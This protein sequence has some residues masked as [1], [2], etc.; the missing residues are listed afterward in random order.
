MAMKEL[1]IGRVEVLTPPTDCGDTK[2]FTNVVTWA[3]DAEGFSQTTNYVFEKYGW[4]LLG[5]EECGPVRERRNF[6]EDVLDAIEDAKGNQNACI[7]T[8]FFY[9]PS[10]PL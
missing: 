4:S 6:G 2:A 9:Y 1:W 10:R 7:Y 3:S 8:T 5:V